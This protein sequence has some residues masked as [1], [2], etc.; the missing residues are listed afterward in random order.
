MGDTNN[1]VTTN[2][3]TTGQTQAVTT[4]S[5]ET[6]IDSA[7]ERGTEQKTNAIL[8]SYFKQQGMEESEIQEAIKNW[9]EAKE[10]EKIEKE[11][12]IKEAEAKKD[13]AVRDAEAKAE[14]A[15]N[16]LKQ[17]KINNAVKDAA[18]TLGVNPERIGLFSKLI[19]TTSIQ[20]DE[21]YNV[22]SESIKKAISDVLEMAPEFKKSPETV[23]GFKFGATKQETTEPKNTKNLTLR[24]SLALRYNS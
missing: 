9:K 24:E 1:T 12:A 18:I 13:Q 7:I 23:T 5:S 11:N 3:E 14:A 21:N 2:T 19:D 16:L 15:M 4:N 20:I 8:K 10:K 17:E 6:N 22:D